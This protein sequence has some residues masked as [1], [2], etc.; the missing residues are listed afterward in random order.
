MGSAVVTPEQATLIVDSRYLEQAEK[1]TSECTI[2]LSKDP[3]N[4]GTRDLLKEFCVD[5]RVAVEARILSYDSILKIQSWGFDIVPTFDV[6]RKLR[7]VKSPAEIELLRTAA[8]TAGLALRKF[9]SD[10]PWG[11][12]E[13]LAAGQLDY[14]CRLLGSQGPSFETIVASGNGTSLPH[15]K[16][17]AALISP[18]DNLLIDFGIRRESYCSDTTRMIV[19]E[20]NSSIKEIFQIVKDAQE[21]AIAAVKPGVSAASVD[22]SARTVIREAGYGDNFG[23]SVGHGLGLE[24]HEFPYISPKSEDTLEEGM[25]FTIEPGIYL[26]GEFGIRIEDTAVVTQSGCEII[27]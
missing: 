26:P 17:G 15:A 22:H 27:S 10:I 13:T 5:Q 9:L 23:H 3:L 14:Q 8:Q 18:Q 16:P 20:R 19:P 6:V 21:S 24:V 11:K 2:R 1:E 25:V 12:T 7:A 4:E